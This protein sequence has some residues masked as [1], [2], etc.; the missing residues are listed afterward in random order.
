MDE[1]DNEDYQSNCDGQESAPSDTDF[2]SDSDS[3]FE[4]EALG[5]Q[6]DPIMS[7]ERRLEKA[8]ERKERQEL[9][10]KRSEPVEKWCKCGNCV[11]GP[12]TENVCCV[13][14]DYAKLLI[15]SAN[16]TC[17]TLHEGFEPTTLNMYV[18]DMVKRHLL[19]IVHDPE[20]KERLRSNNNDTKRHLAY[21]NFRNWVCSGEKLGKG[22]RIVTPSCV[23]TKIRNKW[24]EESNIYVG[25][26]EAMTTIEDL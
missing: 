26:H 5:F 17:I 7:E 14:D 8:K 23:V 3:S 13:D 20:K 6:F 10:A 9:L 2:S 25:F 4:G 12:P 16:I 21:V 22:H 15:D 24:P 19:L 18:L 11:D 1:I